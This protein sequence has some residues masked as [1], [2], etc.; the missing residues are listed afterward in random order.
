MNVHG[1]RLVDYADILATRCRVDFQPMKISLSVLAALLGSI[2]A[3]R[4]VG[5]QSPSPS[6]RTLYPDSPARANP[7]GSAPPRRMPGNNPDDGKRGPRG[8]LDWERTET[9]S[10]D[11]RLY[12]TLSLD[13]R[14]RV[15]DVSSGKSEVELPAGV[16]AAVFSPD[17]RLLACRFEKPAGGGTDEVRY[18]K[19]FNAADG[20][21]VG[22]PIGKGQKYVE[23]LEAVV[24]TPDGKRLVGFVGN[25]ANVGVGCWNVDDGKAAAVQPIKELYGG[26]ALVF[27]PDGKT[28]AAV[29]SGSAVVLLNAADLKPLRTLPA[30]R[31]SNVA[32]AFSPDG[33]LLA[34]G[35]DEQRVVKGQQDGYPCASLYE[36]AGGKP[37]TELKVVA[38]RGGRVRQI[39]FTDAGRSVVTATDKSAQAWS[40]ADG[41]LLAMLPDAG[42]P[43]AVSADGKTLAGSQYPDLACWDTAAW[44]L[45]M[46]IA[47][48]KAG[49]GTGTGPMSYVPLVFTVDGT[50]VTLR[51]NSVAAWELSGGRPVAERAGTQSRVIY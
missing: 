32:A 3:A 1:L 2:A 7:N 50:I 31:K 28:L 11:G 17:S 4:P 46:K 30:D 25:G 39:L 49:Y 48:A 9:L 41:R 43:L 51:G 45:G 21:P 12:V 14:M 40:A 29:G 38:H 24:F 15:W 23:F 5:A 42:F 34:V 36:V 19:V 20:K 33:R 26:G 37:A 18:W 47:N 6:S 13:G 35:G 44:H 8:P 10:P 16:I 22:E 27:S